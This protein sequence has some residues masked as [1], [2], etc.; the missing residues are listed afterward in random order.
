[1]EQISLNLTLEEVNQI[2]DSLGQRPYVDVFQ[3]IGKI[4]A[5][6]EAQL[7]AN[8]MRQQQLNPVEFQVNSPES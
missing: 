1:M 3:L 6:A 2:L 8:K 5:Q 4:Q 7:Q